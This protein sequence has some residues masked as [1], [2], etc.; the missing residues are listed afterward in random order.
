MTQAAYDQDT[1]DFEGRPEAERANERALAAG[2]RIEDRQFVDY[3][4]TP[5]PTR[6]YL[7]DGVQYF[8]YVELREGG[9][10]LYEKATNKDIR[11]QRST[12]D[13]RLSVDPA[14]QR[15][16]LVKL[17]VVDANLLESDGHGGSRKIPF[18]K[19]R[20]GKFWENLFTFFPAKIIEDLN[21]EIIKANSWLAADDDVEALKEERDRLDERIERAEEEQAKK[22]L[23]LEQAGDFV[24]GKGISNPH[25]ALLIYAR[26]EAMKW[27]IPYTPGGMEDQSVMLLRCFDLIN[28]VKND[29]ERQENKKREQEMKARQ[30]T[31]KTSARR[32]R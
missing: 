11:V 19:E 17:S 9:K 14:V 21:Q 6:Y 8:D 22:D 32:R 29:H 10:A 2:E 24:K 1:S 27:A 7:P 3:F 20:P 16:T 18:N 12:G 15:Q 5:Q 13:A 31:P 28:R 30:K 23:L 26:L 25:P 4:A